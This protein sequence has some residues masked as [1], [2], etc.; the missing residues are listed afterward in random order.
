V[1]AELHI[2]PVKTMDEVLELALVEGCRPKRAR[3]R[4]VPS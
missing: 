2:V 1:R 4:V 3:H